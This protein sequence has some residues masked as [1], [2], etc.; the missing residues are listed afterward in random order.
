MVLL[1]DRALRPIGPARWLV[2][3]LIYLLMAFAIRIVRVSELRDAVPGSPN[4]ILRVLGE[5]IKEKL[6][7]KIGLGKRGDPYRYYQRVFD[8]GGTDD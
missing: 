7:R 8:E 3:G 4:D 1:V 6:V 2:D 5:L